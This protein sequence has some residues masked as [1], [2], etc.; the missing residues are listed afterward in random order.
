MTK[1]MT[2]EN[3]PV[4]GAVCLDWEGRRVYTSFSSDLDELILNATT[5]GYGIVAIEKAHAG[6]PPVWT[7]EEY[8]A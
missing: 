4:Y 8:D 5:V 2:K 3:K 6:E 1:R 7:R